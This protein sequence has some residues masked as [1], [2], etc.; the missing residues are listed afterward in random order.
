MSQ[1]SKVANII[2]IKGGK[3]ITSL[4]LS[5]RSLNIV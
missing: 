5:R 4:F 1:I 2:L 3:M